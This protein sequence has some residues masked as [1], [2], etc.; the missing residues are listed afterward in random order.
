M[1]C[2]SGSGSDPLAT[3]LR[4][5]NAWLVDGE[6]SP[7]NHIHKL[8]LYGMTTAKYA[9]KK[10]RVYWSKDK[11]KILFDGR[12]LCMDRFR[13]FI[14]SL[15]SAAEEILSRDLLFGDGERVKSMD[16]SL[17][18]DDVNIEN[19]DYSFV[20]E[21]NNGL[22]GGHNR[23][24][25]RLAKSDA[26][27]RLVGAGADGWPPKPQGVQ[28]Y[29]LAVKKFLEYML[30]LIHIAGGQPARGTEITSIRHANVMHASRNIFIM[31]GQVMVVTEYHKSQ[32]VTDQPKVIPRFLPDR[33]GRLLVVYLADVLPFRQLITDCAYTSESGGF[34]WAG[35]DGKP[36]ETDD[37]TRVMT[38]ES[39][40]RLGFRLTTQ[41][42]RHIAVA[43]DREHV[44]GLTA[45]MDLDEEDDPHDLMACHS[46]A[47]AERVYGVD[48]E[49]L[50]SLSWRSVEIFRNIAQR[51]HDFLGLD[52]QEEDKCPPRLKT[53][54]PTEQIPGAKRRGV[55]ASA[56]ASTTMTD[57]DGVVDLEPAMQKELEMR[58]LPTG[59]IPGAKRRRVEASA[60]ANATMADEDDVVDLEPAMQKE[61]EKFIGPGASF[62]SPEQREGLAAVLRGESPVVAILPTGGGKSLLFMLPAQL[63]DARTTIVVAPFV[64]LAEDIANR[65]GA[66]G[67]PC[68]QWR[69]GPKYTAPVVI[70]SAEAAVTGRFMSYAAGLCED[71]KLDRIVIDECHL[72]VTAAGYR[73]CLARL[74]ELAIPVPL[75]LLTATMPPTMEKRLEEAMV[76]SGARYIRASTHRWNFAY[77]VKKCSTNEIED[78]ACWMVKSAEQRMK[79]EERIVVFCRT[80]DQC[81]RLAK[82]LGCG[83][84][85]S[86]YK[87]KKT[88]LESWIKGDCK[89]AVATGALGSGVDLP[90]ISEVIHVGL[91]Y[92]LVDYSQESG[93]AGRRG[94]RVRATILVSHGDYEQL[95]CRSKESLTV[96][97][98]ALQSYITTE[99]CRRVVLGGYLDGEEGQMECSAVAGSELCDQCRPREGLRARFGDR[100]RYEAR[101]SE[102][103]KDVQEK[104]LLDKQMQ[105]VL[106]ELQGKCVHCWVKDGQVNGDHFTKSCP[107][108]QDSGGGNSW[109]KTMRG[110][111]TYQKHACCFRCSAPP[112][113]CEYYKQGK[114]CKRNDV[115][116]A[117]SL[118]AWSIESLRPVIERVAGREF[119][120]EE[121]LAWLGKKA[122]GQG[123]MRTNAFK[124]F[125]AIVSHF[126]SG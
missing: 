46:T 29:E 38:R 113:W 124:A 68:I 39:G 71:G 63:K 55:R 96:D 9:G 109:Y 85:H 86:T 69:P 112:D 19:I 5:R 13:G 66:A 12:P 30:I 75:I 28:E 115:V 103:Q 36:W 7:F 80:R 95:R 50:N 93:R 54:L 101:V 16:L 104:S 83:T 108:W 52:S 84:Y 42:Y 70:V 17:L 26:L 34:L 82:R 18:T 61:L 81:E 126:V 20:C 44:R 47:V 88:S 31:N 122:D 43:I 106:E 78:Q 119:T 10:D 14:Q 49:I 59:Q 60:S 120:D 64:A 25:A 114:T 32:A 40:C 107:K 118:S 48:S 89:V 102:V 33:I 37:L 76:I 91:P 97:E 100:G 92:S 41:A 94:E 15:I 74:K 105:E 117:V 21:R 72:T 77:S 125:E 65:C 3:F 2:G 110:R 98:E 111:L 56:S 121:Y 87:D 116:A 24:L 45:G 1:R 58:P 22:Q 79:E 99:G 23:M 11:K 8:L 6:P 57:E 27:T 67:I 51:W 73:A 35:K 90:G 123:I 4:V 53:P 62:K